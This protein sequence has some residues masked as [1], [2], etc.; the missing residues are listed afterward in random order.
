MKPLDKNKL[1]EWKDNFDTALT[2]LENVFLSKGP[3]VNGAADITVADLLCI[4][5]LEQPLAAG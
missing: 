1:E 3:F 4:C 5:E 2:R